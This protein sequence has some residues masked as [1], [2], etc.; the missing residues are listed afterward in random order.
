MASCELAGTYNDLLRS[1]SNLTGGVVTWLRR[2]V[3]I[4]VNVDLLWLNPTLYFGDT[5]SLP[6]LQ[7]RQYLLDEKVFGDS[8][9]FSYSHI[10]QILAK[11]HGCIITTFETMTVFWRALLTKLQFYGQNIVGWITR[12][13]YVSRPL[14]RKFQTVDFITTTRKP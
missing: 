1:K 13:L 3:V 8:F 2:Y 12:N 14:P 6:L 5:I 7:K 9:I 11:F 10:W 4:W